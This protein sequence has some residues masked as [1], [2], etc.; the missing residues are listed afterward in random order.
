MLLRF[1]EIPSNIHP[2]SAGLL[3]RLGGGGFRRGKKK[4][5]SPSYRNTHHKTTSCRG[6]VFRSRFHRRSKPAM[7]LLNLPLNPTVEP[8][9]QPASDN[10]L[11]SRRASFSSRTAAKSISSLISHSIQSQQLPFTSSAATLSPSPSS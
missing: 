2:R 5:E 7:G 11:Y 9:L 3:G 4:C 10:L 6:A 8:R 1:A